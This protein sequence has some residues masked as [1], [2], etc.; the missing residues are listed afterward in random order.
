[1]PAD[2][3]SVDPTRTAVLRRRYAQHYR[4]MWQRVITAINQYVDGVDFRQTQAQRMMEF[5]RF[6]DDLLQREFGRAQADRDRGIR[7]MAIMAY[8]RGLAQAKSETEDDL[9]P[10]L[11]IQQPEHND[12]IAALIL[13]LSTQLMGVRIN[14]TGQ[15]LQRY[16]QA[17][18]VDDAKAALRDRVLKVGRTPTDGIAADGVVRGYN[19]ALLNVYQAAG[20]DYVGVIEEKAFLQTAED[21][22]V[23]NQCHSAS[24]IT[25]NGYGPGIYT[26]SQAR[27]LL[28]LHGRCRCR[29]RPLPPGTMQS[30]GTQTAGRSRRYGTWRVP[31]ELPPQ[32]RNVQGLRRVR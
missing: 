1:M 24:Q 3:R 7:A 18:G 15:L 22:R 16:Q 32:N 29:W 5:N 20:V 30:A 14:L 2:V 13:L 11:A 31:A 6:V 8:M 12:A 26:I 28:P 17:N 25:D 9:L 23:C 10:S 19:D 27:G 21:D 4:A